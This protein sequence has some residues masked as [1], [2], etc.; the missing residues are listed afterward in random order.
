MDLT[1][2]YIDISVGETIGSFE[3]NEPLGRDAKNRTKMTIR[4]DGKESISFIKLINKYNGYAVLDVLIETGRTHQIRVHLDSKNLPIIGD[5]AYNARK[6]IA[7]NSSPELIKYIREFPRQALH[8]THISFSHHKT[9][10]LFEWSIEMPEDMKK[11]EEVI[12]SG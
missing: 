5:S 12:I 8:A 4:H 9:N 10:E 1:K 3:I 7:K 11:L 2:K 6:R